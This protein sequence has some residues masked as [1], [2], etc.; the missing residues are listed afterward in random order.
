MFRNQYSD[1]IRR[2]FVLTVAMAFFV[3]LT[4][5]SQAQESP[6]TGAA[7]SASV[8]DQLAEPIA[9][10]RLK[11]TDEQ[12]VK[13]S[14]LKTKRTEALQA[15]PQEKKGEVANEFDKQAAALLTPEQNIAFQSAAAE[16]K[17]KFNFRYQKWIDVL[18]WFAKQSNLS[19]VLDAPP[20]ATFT[21]T[22]DREYTPAE[23]IDL[24][25]GVLYSKGYTLVRRNRMLLVIDLNQGIPDNALP[26]VTMDELDKRGRYEFVSV[27]FPLEGRDPSAV[28]EEIKPLL[29]PHG[30]SSP[31]PATKQ[32]LISDTAGIMR[33]IK[34]V[35]ESIPKPA[36]PPKPEQKPPA[37]PKELK[38]YSADGLDLDAAVKVLVALTP[39]AQV[40]PDPKTMQLNIHAT[41]AEHAT[42]KTVLDQMLA[43]TQS[44]SSDQPTL[45]TYPLNKADTTEVLTALKEGLPE[46]KFSVNERR[47]QLIA[48]A[49]PSDHEKIK[50]AL[51]KMVSTSSEAVTTRR[52]QV[53]HL[54]KGNPR[55]LITVLQDLV[56]NAQLAADPSSSS[57]IAVASDADHE[58]IKA[59]IKELVE[60]NQDLIDPEVKYYPLTNAIPDELTQAVTAMAPTAKLVPNLKE[61]RLM[62]IAKPKDQVKIKELIEKFKLETAIGEKPELQNY[63]VTSLQRSRFD[64][65][66][67][68]LTPDFPDLKVIATN[69]PG[70][71]SLWGTASQHT[72]IK[73]I[74]DG[75]KRNP[76]EPDNFQLTLIPLKQ[77][78]EGATLLA[79]LQTLFPNVKLTHDS[80]NGRLMLWSTPEEA[81]PIQAAVDKLQTIEPELKFY[82]FPDGVPP[83]LITALSTFVPKAQVTPDPKGKRLMVIASPADHSK[84]QSTIDKV[85]SDAT[86][87]KK[88]KLV[89]Y[90]VTS[91]QKSRFESLM[92]TLSTD[93]PDLKVLPTTKPG[94]LSI[95][96]TPEQH[97]RLEGLLAELGKEVEPG[98]A[99]KL[100]V[101][102]LKYADGPTTLNLL[103]TLFPTTKISFDA[104]TG[105]ISVFGNPDQ[106]ESIRQAIEA[107]DTDEPPERQEKFMVYPVHDLDPG[108]AV[109]MLSQLVPK[110]RV[111]QDTRAR[112]LV[113][114]AR[115]LDHQMISKTLQTL[116]DGAT[117]TTKMR[118]EIYPVGSSGMATVSNLVRNVTPDARLIPDQGTGGV[119]VWAV[120]SDHEKITSALKDLEIN[121]GERDKPALE[122]YKVR[123]TTP[124]QAA[125]VIQ[126]AVPDVRISYNSDPEEF[127]VWGLPS[128]Q[129][130]V[131]KI[132]S[133][134]EAGYEEGA[135]E[136][137]V[138]YSVPVSGAS[139]AIGPLRQGIP[140]A[141]I[142]YA[143][144]PDKLVIW[145]K[146]FDH[147]KAVKIIR[148]LEAK[149][150]VDEQLTMQ[151][152]T[153]G[154]VTSGTAI[155][156]L[157][158]ALPKVGFTADGNDNRKF[159]A[160]GRPG[161][162]EQITKLIPQFDK[163]SGDG[164]DVPYLQ[165]YSM[166][167]SGAAQAYN[168]AYRLAPYASIN[169]SS[170]QTK[171]IVW[172]RKTEQ[173]TIKELTD[174]IEEVGNSDPESTLEVYS[175]SSVGAGYLYPLIQRAVPK[176]TYTVGSDPSQLLVWA[177]P[178]E[179]AQ[180]KK[181]VEGVKDAP[182]GEAG[183]EVVVYKVTVLPAGSMLP[184]LQR[185]VP[186]ANFSMGPDQ[187]QLVVWAKPAEHEIV[188]KLIDQLEA[189]PPDEK[190]G[191]VMIYSLHTV[192]AP[193]AIPVLQKAVPRAT[194]TIGAD[195]NKLVVWGQPSEHEIVKKIVEQLEAGASTDEKFE[196]AVYD[197]QRAGA[198]NALTVL[199][200]VLPR[201][202]F[203]TGADPSKLIAWAK[204][205]DQVTIQKLVENLNQQLDSME[206]NS[207]VY[208]F[209]TADPQAAYT[210]L[211]TLVPTARLA[212][213]QTQR[214]IIATATPK[215]HEKLAKAVAE[216]DQAGEGVGKPIV[217]S[218][219]TGDSE[220]TS[221]WNMMY[222][223]FQGRTDTKVTVDT[224][225]R[226]IVIS[227]PE[228]Q[229]KIAQ[230]VLD[231]ILKNNQQ[232]TL[233]QHPLK[234]ADLTAATQVVNQLLRNDLRK[235][236]VTPDSEGHQL[237]VLGTPKHHQ[238]VKD[239]I[240]SL[241]R[242]KQNL[243]VITLDTVDA[244]TAESTIR[245][246]LNGSG[247]KGPSVTIDSDYDKQQLY[248][249]AT[250]S[251]MTEI[252]DLLAKMGERMPES[253]IVSPKDRG[254]TRTIRFEGDLASALKQI[255]GVWPRIRKNKIKV[256][257][258]SHGIDLKTPSGTGN[259]IKNDSGEE[260][261]SE[262]LF[263]E[264]ET[265]SLDD[266][267][268]AA[269]NETLTEE[270]ENS[271]NP[272][273]EPEASAPP[274][275]ESPAA[276]SQPA[277]EIP[278]DLSREQQDPQEV[279][280][281]DGKDE[282][283]KTTSEATEES[284]SAPILIVPGE[285]EIT[286]SSD[287]LDALDQLENLLKNMSR[288][289][290]NQGAGR[291]F[292]IYM[293]KNTGAK[294]VADNLEDLFGVGQNRRGRSRFNPSGPTIVA[295]ERINAI[296]VHG[297]RTDRESIEDLLK[298]MD[299]PELLDFQSDRKTERFVLKNAR[300]NNIEDIL[301][302]LYR[303]QLANISN[304]QPIPIP[305]GAS[306]EVITAIQTINAATSAPVL[307]LTVDDTT[308]SVIALGPEA[309]VSEVGNVIKDLDE[310]AVQD[311]S[312]KLSIIPLKK[313]NAE[314]ARRAL[315]AVLQDNTRGRRRG[316]N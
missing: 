119:V 95:W 41:E 125:S 313:L 34:A 232:M 228:Q 179:H 199:Q 288:P 6:P 146:P 44:P 28:N 276:E 242:E 316:G 14:E 180:I 100:T 170:D 190:P 203:T 181:M 87:L 217:R 37:P 237:I 85:A 259:P 250:P 22:D 129:E 153:T 19:L 299:S 32:I 314:H 261:K 280:P 131:K 275:T 300:A 61:K 251:Q 139:N 16:P 98:E 120:P 171:L 128:D 163:K 101:F 51:E 96:A 306:L 307:T 58:Q 50:Q 77:P 211:A 239:A 91:E 148:E 184:M 75:L 271:Q 3:G 177:R 114:Y 233:E 200:R 154:E 201:V 260:K 225:N 167:K 311:L 172:G 269:V 74:L 17:L 226:A 110:A 102:P 270:Q 282:A 272:F 21:Y 70:T 210:A 196:L 18:E 103:Q 12:R 198:Q 298:V 151:V 122:T 258:P 93:F 234:D 104:Q 53:Y 24:L 165:I 308:N 121:V 192:G 241:Q 145:A 82:P 193:Q 76:E 130:M 86:T 43:K 168:I 123:K 162:H 266:A 155:T 81:A 182:T 60:G 80:T 124:S 136:S 152:Y 20:P 56:P 169:L 281:D 268:E 7:S 94:V 35:I 115:Q 52:I 219:T 214:T 289:E 248:V 159:I 63:P 106:Q 40:I 29:G 290:R 59:T 126:S 243:E 296:L 284:E 127:N 140:F 134:L 291:D 23:A 117:A 111:M 26:R 174:R 255:E 302:D 216:I 2:S 13:I 46:V 185:A 253:S 150:G 92:Q 220:S 135:E 202:T 108:V 206:T 212:L 186:K 99:M 161:D 213:D 229:H 295:D 147:E 287:D 57:L 143:S 301:R 215:D 197:I 191:E 194:F 221:V 189:T 309:L 245:R 66:L 175:V 97:T 164:T 116:Q 204:P 209:E 30:K 27:L 236:R 156:I 222:H 45:E 1:F 218:Y 149:S 141:S 160:W 8:L 267:L 246:M 33:S 205:A 71:L 277:T 83:T 247:H 305:S 9:I 297:S 88:G 264:E 65:I 254:N 109:S 256:L 230:E 303:S 62:V 223:L 262:A 31:L 315:D 90:P 67:P 265:E 11:L 47:S 118:L 285:N 278:A 36:P 48:W 69:E 195:P 235:V 84:V 188:K 138:I 5:T 227:A 133:K 157:Q 68:T 78:A 207:K 312:R 178:E 112:T 113:V 42:V 257:T 208:H 249:Q 274:T 310:G 89:T 39:G 187:Q 283:P 304:R 15:A 173:E 79:S 10:E 273:T 231:E 224:E 25:N 252:R 132:V 263:E 279:A 64:A 49:L 238:M 72:L 38:I 240:E 73:E 54:E 137:M 158:R 294:Q 107:I 292:T 105:K 55:N 293:L 183:G 166:P 144:D 142:S 4:L 244:F 286:I 176:A